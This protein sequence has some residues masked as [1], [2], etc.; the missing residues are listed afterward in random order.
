VLS[1]L[2]LPIEER[3]DAEIS[4]FGDSG[5]NILVEFWMLGIDDRENRVRAEP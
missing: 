5:V 1:G 2:E 4:R 3:P